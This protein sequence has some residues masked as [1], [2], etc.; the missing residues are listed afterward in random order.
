[1]NFYFLELLI[2]SYTSLWVN[3]AL[4]ID[5]TLF[6]RCPTSALGAVVI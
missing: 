2:I 3:E 1:M 6:K 4:A 5:V